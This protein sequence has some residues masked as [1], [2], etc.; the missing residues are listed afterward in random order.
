[1][2]RLLWTTA[3]IQLRR[4]FREKARS[5]WRRPNVPENEI[6]KIESLSIGI[7]TSSTCGMEREAW[8][9]EMKRGLAHLMVQS[10]A[11]MRCQPTGMHRPCGWGEEM[12]GEGLSKDASLANKGYKEKTSRGDMERTI[13]QGQSEGPSWWITST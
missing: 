9:I 8:A 11:I 3:R 4:P 2:Q 10:G 1:M 13:E 12:V 7:E 6:D 5:N